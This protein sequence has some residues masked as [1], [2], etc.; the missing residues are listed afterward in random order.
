ML[1]GGEK[2]GTRGIRATWGG[3]QFDNSD[4][5]DPHGSLWLMAETNEFKG[6]ALDGDLKKPNDE[7]AVFH[8][9]FKDEYALVMSSAT[10][11]SKRWR[12]AM[13][14]SALE[15]EEDEFRRTAWTGATRACDTNR[16]NQ[17]PD[18]YGHYELVSQAV[19]S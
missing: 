14:F 9:K 4:P 11:S 15:G 6:H 3:Q 13:S 8:T 16:G 10:L 19:R 2:L 18:V 17:A 7:M 5:F 1:Q 12:S